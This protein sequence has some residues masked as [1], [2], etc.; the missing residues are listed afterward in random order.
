MQ[1]QRVAHLTRRTVNLEKSSGRRLYALNISDT[2][3]SF[4]LGSCSR[5]RFHCPHTNLET[6]VPRAAW[7]CRSFLDT[8]LR[9]EAS[10]PNCPARTV[11]FVLAV[12]LPRFATCQRKS[13]CSTYQTAHLII[14]IAPDS[15]PASSDDTLPTPQVWSRAAATDRSLSLSPPWTSQPRKMSG[16][17]R[18]SRRGG[19]SGS[20][21]TYLSDFEA[22]GTRTENGS[23]EVRPQRWPKRS[24]PPLRPRFLVPSSLTAQAPLTAPQNC[25]L[26]TAPDVWLSRISTTHEQHL[27]CPWKYVAVNARLTL[28]SLRVPRT[29]MG[30]SQRLSVE[31]KLGGQGQRFPPRRAPSRQAIGRETRGSKPTPNDETCEA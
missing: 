11:I 19:C 1:Q 6:T 20:S 10:L 25:Y 9:H 26:V 3:Q 31:S 14:L 5:S 23:R 7:V 18:T 16:P 24:I 13:A 15:V 21:H 4:L 12:D 2:M 17:T 22:G 28:A 8:K 29:A 27:P 30:T